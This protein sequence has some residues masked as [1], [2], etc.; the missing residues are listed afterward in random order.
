[1]AR[2]AKRT[3]TVALTMF[4]DD[5][6][7]DFGLLAAAVTISLIPI[8]G[9]YIVLKDKIMAGMAAGSVKG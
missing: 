2:P 3:I 1:M 4:Y 6:Q 7:Q 9:T 8:M 5:R